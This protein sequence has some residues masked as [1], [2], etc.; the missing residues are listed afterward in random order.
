MKYDIGD[1]VW[2]R[3]DLARVE[4]RQDSSRYLIHLI[5]DARDRIEY[6]AGLE[7]VVHV[8][9]DGQ[10]DLWDLNLNTGK[11]YMRGGL[12]ELFA[13]RGHTRHELESYGPLTDA[14]EEQPEGEGASVEAPRVG[15]YLKP[16]DAVYQILGYDLNDQTAEVKDVETGQVHTILLEFYEETKPPLPK[17]GQVWTLNIDGDV[18][19][20]T[21]A[22]HLGEY[23]LEMKSAFTEITVAAEE[24]LRGTSE[25]TRIF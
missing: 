7:P 25:W 3:G 15:S 19:A 11:Y 22:R 1:Y 23:T 18:V 17:V 9:E 14:N 20:Y 8:Y 21:V 16:K 5:E 13:S 24:L 4:H 2:F 10:G 12:N 6:G